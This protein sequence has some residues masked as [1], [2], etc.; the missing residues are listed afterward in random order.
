MN[1]SN[2]IIIPR[3]KRFGE[4]K[5]NPNVSYSDPE[6]LS[7]FYSPKKQGP[8]KGYNMSLGKKS[9]FARPYKYIPGVGSYKLPS[10]WDKYWIE[11]Y[12]SFAILNTLFHFGASY[13]CSL[14][15]F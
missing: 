10:I 15:F 1:S 11:Y 9:D 7:D 14:I 5:A 12:F 4:Y 3:A 13:K 2:E 6:K 8:V